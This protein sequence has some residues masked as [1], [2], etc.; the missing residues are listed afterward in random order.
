MANFQEALGLLLPQGDFAE[1]VDMCDDMWLTWSD[2]M[3]DAA[4]LQEALG[5][6]LPQGNFP[7]DLVVCDGM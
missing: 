5:L 4:D 7:G 6:L 3:Q 2:N 1:A